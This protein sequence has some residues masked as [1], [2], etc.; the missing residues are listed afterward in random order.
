MNE[1]YGYEGC[2]ETDTK[3]IP[4]K[5][6]LHLAAFLRHLR[7]TLVLDLDSPQMSTRSLSPYTVQLFIFFVIW[8][9]LYYIF[10]HYFIINII[11]LLLYIIYLSL[12]I[13]SFIYQTLCYIVIYL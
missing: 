5:L 4:T 8:K 7:A 12:Y 13:L 3:F 6:T 11:Y 2:E 10:I 1:G 9:T